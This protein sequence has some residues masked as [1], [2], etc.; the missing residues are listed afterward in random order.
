MITLL[1]GK[2]GQV[3][4]ELNLSLLPLGEVVAI[5]WAQFDL[6]HPEEIL[7]IIQDIKPDIIVNVTTDTVVDKAGAG[8]DVLFGKESFRHV[9]R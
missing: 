5:G 8:W 4:W 9:T 7:G 6:S 1:V 3:G 2:N